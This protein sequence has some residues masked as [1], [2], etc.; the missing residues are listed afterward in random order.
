VITFWI[1]L[2]IAVRLGLLTL[3]GL[4]AGALANYLI[5]GFAYFNRRAISPWGHGPEGGPARRASDR[6]PVFGWWGLRRES[7][8]HGPGFWIRPMLIEL[9]M[10]LALIWLY[11]FE[12]QWGGLLPPSLRFP[13]FLDG[14]EA[15]ATHT[16]V[17]HGLLLVLMTA[18]TFIDFD[19]WTIPDIITIPGTLLALLLAALSTEIFM[20]TIIVA[21]GVMQ[22]LPTTFDSPWFVP[23]KWMAE[24]GLITGWAIWTAWCFSLADWRWSGALARRRGVPRA[25]RHFV[26]G[27][28]HDGFWK[29]LA[30]IWILGAIGILWCWTINGATWLG[31]F[32]ALTGL[33]VGGGVTWS[34]RLVATWALNMEAMG[35]GD[36]TLM[37]MIGAMLGWQAALIA[38]FLSPFAAIV[39]VLVRYVITRDAYTPF[40]PYLCAGAA[41]TVF[42]WDR[43]YNG[44]LSDNLLLMGPVLLWFSLAMLGL[45]GLLLF[46][47]RHIKLRL[48]GDR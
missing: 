45:M 40:G 5:Y 47:W 12:T 42:W 28:F 41:M 13:Q 20:P 44:W 33:A 11:F 43:L 7:E 4:A 27:L 19:D 34:I 16:F 8:I 36:V 31:L 14:Y 48:F 9:G 38:F 35:F 3:L 37:G 26:N 30:G 46:V 2:P 17:A 10:P 39:I 24:N 1:G 32:S 29:V 21:G 6:V 22:V 15:T 18:A 23:D 25:I